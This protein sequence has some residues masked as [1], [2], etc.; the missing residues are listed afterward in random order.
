MIPAIRHHVIGGIYFREMHLPAGE[1]ALTHV[2]KYDHASICMQG[3]GIVYAEE[4]LPYQAG[5]IV[6]IKAGISHG[7]HAT[8]DTVWL[9]C[10][11][12]EGCPDDLDAVAISLI[13]E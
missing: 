6:K 1:E 4:A 3:S 10:H 12:S 13:K 9:C 8:T 5:D 7:I 11:P 2:H